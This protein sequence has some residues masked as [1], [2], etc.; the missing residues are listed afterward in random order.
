VKWIG[1]SYPWSFLMSEPI[2]KFDA[3]LEDVLFEVGISE[4]PDECLLA[5]DIDPDAA[6]RSFRRRFKGISRVQ[7]YVVKPNPLQRRSFLPISLPADF[8]QQSPKITSR[9]L[10]RVV[11]DLLVK[12]CKAA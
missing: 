4:H 12:A 8:I 10:A 9:K 5:E 7:L 6:I 3:F 1:D 11:Y 2:P